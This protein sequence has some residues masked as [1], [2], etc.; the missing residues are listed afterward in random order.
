M[1]LVIVGVLFVVLIGISY[2]VYHCYKNKNDR[3]KYRMLNQSDAFHLE[4]G[5]DDELFRLDGQLDFG[6]EVEV[7][8]YGYAS[9]PGAGGPDFGQK[10]QLDGHTIQKS[11]G[12]LEGNDDDFDSE[13]W[14]Q[15]LKQEYP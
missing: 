7:E 5:S 15:M 10:Q 11:L 14:G 2:W 12:L 13:K 6:D 8:E 4:E 9:L 3:N 1:L